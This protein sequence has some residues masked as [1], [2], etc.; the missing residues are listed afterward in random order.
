MSRDEAN[1]PRESEGRRATAPGILPRRIGVIGDVHA[2]D[3]A[4]RAGLA[5]LRRQSIDL[6]LQVG[7]IVDGPG[8]VDAC[9]GLLR[10]NGAAA[11][12]G[13][14]ERWFLEGS[15]RGWPEATP[16]GAVN[17]EARAWLAAL[18]AVRTFETAAGRL[19]LCHG[20]GGDDMAGVEPDDEGYALESNDALHALLRLS[21]LRLVVNGHTHHR[22][23]RRFG[24]LTLINAGT[25]C[26][27]HQPCLTI[28][29]LDQGVVRFHALNADLVVGPAAE[30]VPLPPWAAT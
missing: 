23:V 9:C 6:L 4:L 1:A 19:A 11:V 15:M 5:F 16:I 24:S 18:P 12:R 13:N 14:H 17:A 25:L 26:R 10:A 2:E 27:Q 22:M 8:D 29:D 3:G 21:S 28:I 7:D 30:I 20:L